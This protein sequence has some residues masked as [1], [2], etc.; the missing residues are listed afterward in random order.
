MTGAASPAMASPVPNRAASV[1]LLPRQVSMEA[2][3]RDGY[4]CPVAA[5][6]GDETAY[7][8]QQFDA[9]YARHQQRLGALKPS[10]RWQI[11]SDTHFALQWVDELT[12]H[13]QILDAVEQVLGPN[14]LAWNSSWFVKMP[15]DKT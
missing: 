2:F 15:G 12:R 14:I 13:P 9:Y 8:R 6:S 11:N 1:P 4:C 3:D 10:Q 5:L 7:Y